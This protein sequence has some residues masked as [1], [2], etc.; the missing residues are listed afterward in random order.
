MALWHSASRSIA[1][2]GAIY[3]HMLHEALKAVHVADIKGSSPRAVFFFVYV[4][5]T[6]ALCRLAL[7]IG[8]PEAVTEI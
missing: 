8:F 6:F 4:S 7:Q 5:F 2:E 1:L 3:T